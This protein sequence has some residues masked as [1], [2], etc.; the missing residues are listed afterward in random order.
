M[1]FERLIQAVECEATCTGS[2][3]VALQESR[4]GISVAKDGVGCGVQ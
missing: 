3:D 1:C 4:A 2:W